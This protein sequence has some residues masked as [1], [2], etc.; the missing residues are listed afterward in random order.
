MDRIEASF[1]KLEKKH[2]EWSTYVIFSEVVSGKNFSALNI[3]R[4]FKKLVDKSDYEWQPLKEVRAFA[5]S[6]L[7]GGKYAV[8][9]QPKRLSENWKVLIWLN[10][11]FK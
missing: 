2:P 10:T 9:K 1:N 11:R 5:E 3:S 8:K 6:L 7:L 4:N